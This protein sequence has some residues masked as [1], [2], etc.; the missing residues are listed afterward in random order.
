MILSADHL[1]SV[2][3]KP[4]RSVTTS[5]S[6]HYRSWRAAAET[7]PLPPEALCDFFEEPTAKLLLVVE[8]QDLR[9]IQYRILV[10]VL[11]TQ[12]P[13]LLALAD[14]YLVSNFDTRVQNFVFLCVLAANR[15]NSFY[16]HL[17]SAAAR[18]LR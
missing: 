18:Q 15:I 4:L 16:D 17:L 7:H 3:A 10:L 5:E 11:G 12:V 8:R 1:L 13:V 9:T 14:L 6:H 2:V